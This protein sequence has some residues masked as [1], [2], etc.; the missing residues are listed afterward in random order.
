MQ[1]EEKTIALKDFY[2]SVVLKTLGF[3]LLNVQQGEGKFCVFV[4]ADPNLTADAALERY[5]NGQLEKVD[6]RDLIG[7]IKELKNRI[8]ARTM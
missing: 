1:H 2:Q 6:A 8:F 4:F 5:W 7:N 3:H